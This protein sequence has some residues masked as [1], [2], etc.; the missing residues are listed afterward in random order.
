M[1]EQSPDKESFVEVGPLTKLRQ[2]GATLVRAGRW[3]VAVLVEGESVYA[4]D[5]RC[6]HMG[7]PLTKGTVK[8]G[9][10]TCHWH[11]ARFELN[12]GCTF[13]LWADDVPSFETKVEDG[14]V[15]VATT[16]RRDTDKSEYL[17]RLGRGV[18]QNI[19]LVQA[20]SL[21]GL[22]DANA[23]VHEIVR[24]VARVASRRLSTFGEGLV[25]L[26]CVANL[27]FRLNRDVLYHALAYAI[28]QI[29]REF[30]SAVPRSDRQPLESDA[31]D[32]ASLKRWLRQWVL[33]RHR[34][35]TE[36]TILTA[37]AHNMGGDA[38]V[39]DLVYGAANERIYANL[40]HVFD[41]CNKAFELT[42]LIGE[43]HRT[44]IFPLLI[45]QLT[46]SRGQ[47]ESTAWHH[48]IEIIE[49]LRQIEEELPTI[50]QSSRSRDGASAKGEEELVEILLSDEPL[51][52]LEFLKHAGTD[53]VR[54]AAMVAYAAALRLMRF[55]TSNAVTD[56]FNPQHTFIFANAVFCAVRRSA[57]PDLIKGI[58]H[59]A[60]SVYMDRYL[61]VPPA[62]PPTDA[63]LNSL[64][65]DGDEL[66]ELLLET[67]NNRSE[68]DAIARLVSRYVRL[69][70]PLNALIDR[71]ALATVREDLD[72][73]SLQVLEAGAVQC[74]Y[75]RDPKRSEQILLGVVRNLAAHCPTIRAGFQTATIAQRLHRGEKLYEE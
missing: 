7:F 10:L 71:L 50:L 20:K 49:P 1:K 73:H 32:A 54:I 57:T 40:G 42:D 16:P 64:P 3:S 38:E 9:I 31:I 67:T 5:N 65:T 25:R 15:Y 26:T 30:N 68:V 41:A 55:G 17:Q 37:V 53:P 39:P 29:G 8:E 48:P 33:T 46:E 74:D 70:H 43:R 51:R 2:K 28:R 63:E 12:S 60:L 66:L 58:F 72:F 22:F 23:E 52:I 34:D 19:P 27:A 6:P 14:V 11:E 75:H 59:G 18:E 35:A 36:R 61:N 62:K 44:E 24:Q 56:W 13:D 4:V 21:L 69:Q 45:R 47:E